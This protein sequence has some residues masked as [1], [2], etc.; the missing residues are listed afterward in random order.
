MS[1]GSRTL[2]VTKTVLKGGA[3]EIIDSPASTFSMNGR[4]EKKLN[5]C[6]HI[7]W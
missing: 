2:F 7:S 6:P 4:E 1:E 3:D 5:L